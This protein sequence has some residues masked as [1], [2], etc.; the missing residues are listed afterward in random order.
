MTNR[1]ELSVNTKTLQ[2]DM[3]R[4]GASLAATAKLCLASFRVLLDLQ[5]FNGSLEAIALLPPVQS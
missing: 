2:L 3:Q 4:M 1:P 5:L